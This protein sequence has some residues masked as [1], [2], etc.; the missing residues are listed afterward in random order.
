MKLICSQ[1]EKIV[2]KENIKYNEKMSKHTSFKTG[3][4]A[5]YYIKASSVDEIQKIIW[6]SKENKIPLYI[7][8][9]GSNLLVKDEGIR[10][11]VLEINIKNIDIKI[12][13]EDVIINIGAGVKMMEL[14]HILKQKEITGFEELSGIP[15][16]YRWSKF[17]ECWLIWQG[18]ERYNN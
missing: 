13:K 2:S 16:N 3:G 15:R 9:N 1:L 8:G 17:N 10:G 5:D 12:N 6:F 11:I 14:A 4:V 7:I 18:N